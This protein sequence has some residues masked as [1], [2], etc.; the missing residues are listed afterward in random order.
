MIF[1]VSKFIASLFGW[2][3]SKVQKAVLL[4]VTILAAILLF[5][6]VVFFFRHCGPKPATIDQKSINKINAANETERKAELQKVIE[7]NADV[8][9]TVDERNTIAEINEVEK[10]AQIHAKIAEAD[11]KI[12]DAKANGRDV[13]GPEL[14]CLLT[15]NCPQ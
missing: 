11:K 14:E 15:G 13:T 10:Q 7:Q 2:D 4:A 12:A 3:I 9:K 6:I 1:A 5:L 8:V